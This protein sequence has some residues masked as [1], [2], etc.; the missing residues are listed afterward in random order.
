M[1]RE[2][3]ET[4][5]RAEARPVSIAASEAAGEEVFHFLSCGCPI[6]V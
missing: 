2:V 4:K 6:S 3:K 5:A 1:R